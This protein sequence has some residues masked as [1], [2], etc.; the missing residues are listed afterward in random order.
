MPDLTFPHRLG[1]PIQWGV[2]SSGAQYFAHG[3]KMP[4]PIP[5]ST[6]SPFTIKVRSYTSL[7]LLLLLPLDILVFHLLQTCY[8]TIGG[9]PHLSSVVTLPDLLNGGDVGTTH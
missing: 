7:L 5:I 8:G 1:S 6:N 2:V 9:F 4:I 3:V